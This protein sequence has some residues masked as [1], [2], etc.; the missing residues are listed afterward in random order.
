MLRLGRRSLFDGFRIYTWVS[1]SEDTCSS[2]ELYSGLYDLWMPNPSAST[3]T[4]YLSSIQLLALKIVIEL[5][6]GHLEATKLLL[7]E[8]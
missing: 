1:E 8:T 7:K 3:L 4:Q 2:G 5:L 6:G